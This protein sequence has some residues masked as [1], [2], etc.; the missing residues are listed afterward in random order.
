MRFLDSVYEFL[1]EYPRENNDYLARAR[2]MLTQGKI[3][4][5]A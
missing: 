1:V 3:C 2:S 5:L 4:R